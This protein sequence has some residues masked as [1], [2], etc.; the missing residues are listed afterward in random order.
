MNDKTIEDKWREEFEDW[1]KSEYYEKDLHETFLG[2]DDDGRYSLGWI[3]SRF[4]GYLAARKK[5]QE[6]IDNIHKMYKAIELRRGK[7]QLASLI[8][9][10]PKLKEREELIKEA[11]PLVKRI[12]G[13]DRNDLDKKREWLKKAE[14]LTKG[15]G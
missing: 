2:K 4:R 14:E 1:I 13:I 6:E 3:G 11:I 12:V 15:E 9:L 8:K 7:S 5:A 10:F